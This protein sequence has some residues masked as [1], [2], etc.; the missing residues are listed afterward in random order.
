MKT[1]GIKVLMI[2]RPNLYSVRGGD[3]IQIMKTAEYLKKL[4]VEVDIYTEG[5]IHYNNYNLLHFFNVIDP[6]DILGHLYKSKLPYVL[7]PIYVDY[8]EYDKYHRNDLIGK[9]SKVF[10][11]DAVEY[12]KTL[13]KFILKG[14]KVSSRRFFLKGHRASVIHILKNAEILLPNSNSEF[15]RL[16][17]DYGIYKKYTFVPNAIDETLFQQKEETKRDLIICVGRIEGNKN[18]LN[19]IRALKETNY[20]VI[21]IGASAP[22][23]KS[24]YE[25]CKAEANSRMQFIDFIPQEQLLKYYSCAKVHVLASWFETTGLSNLEAGAMG[26]NLVVGRRGDVEEYFDNMVE[27]CEPDDLQSIRTA[28]EKSWNKDASS[29]LQSKIF[30]NFTWKVAAKITHE[31]YQ[32][33]LNH[34]TIR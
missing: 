7:S 23:Q 18:Q 4:G 32:T 19:V 34:D 31:A 15:R 30:N 24:Y 33:I 29:T 11:R 28:V 14:E 25:Q 9:L 13:A 10:S 3:T 22:N 26:C 2:T 27:Y 17:K 6:E 8:R 21:F 20:N 16:Y 12:F 5:T 1:G